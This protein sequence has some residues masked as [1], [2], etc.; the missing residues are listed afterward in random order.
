MSHDTQI[1]RRNLLQVGSAGF[2]GLSLPGL[3][4]AQAAGVADRDN[5]LSVILL[6]MWGGMP[7]QD[8]WDLKPDSRQEVR[9]PYNPIAT[10]VPGIEIG[11]LLPQTARIA[12]QC[13]IVRSVTHSE[14]EHPRA[15]HYMMTGNQIIRGSEW[16]NMGATITRFGGDRNKLGSVVVGPRLIDQP[17]T[18]QGQDGGFLGNSF[19]PFRI[20]DPL[21]PIDKIARLTPPAGVSAQRSI[22]RRRLFD[23]VRSLEAPVESDEALSLDSSYERAFAIMNSPEARQAFDLSQETDD[24]RERYGKHLFGQGALMARRLVSAGVRFVQVN[25]RE[26]PINNNGFDNH[27]DNFKK[28]QEVQAPHVDQTYSALISDLKSRGMLERTLV[29][30]TGEFGR[31]PK[32]N[33]NK[34]RDH[35]PNVFSYLITGGGIPG[36]R[37][38]GASDRDAAYPADNP[39]TPENTLA[40]VFDMVGLDLH[41]LHADGII[42]DTNGVP[43]L[44]SG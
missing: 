19:S 15:A 36:G 10:S 14:I 8:M 1:P 9:G 34:G 39:V 42:D 13:T 25:W 26:H 11:E 2:L 35:W 33:K 32:I 6:F 20:A 22:Q 4:R 31:T 44:F 27:S 21:Q 29:L 43:G 28:L 40:S 16:P 41:K 37:V 17:I 30:M 12:D 3:L 5:D 18:P 7:H 23:L 24:T 38:L